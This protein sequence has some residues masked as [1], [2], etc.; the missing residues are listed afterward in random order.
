MRT[1]MT[2]CEAIA[3]KA[4]KATAQATG[5]AE[6]RC[7]YKSWLLATIAEAQRFAASAEALADGGVTFWAREMAEGAAT[8][9]VTRL[10]DVTPLA[11][12]VAKQE[13]GN[14]ALVAELTACKVRIHVLEAPERQAKRAAASGEGWSRLADAEVTIARLQAQLAE[15]A[16][17][18]ATADEGCANCGGGLPCYCAVTLDADGYATEGARQLAEFEAAPWQEGPMMLGADDGAADFANAIEELQAVPF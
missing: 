10:S 9:Q 18:T 12:K 1:K 16:P 14:A 11:V 5:K 4:D 2:K 7:Q 8:R 13:D 3:R 17:W 6:L 15:S